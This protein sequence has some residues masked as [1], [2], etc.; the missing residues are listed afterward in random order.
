[1]TRH[2]TVRYC[3]SCPGVWRS[4]VAWPGMPGSPI[5]S[6][7]SCGRLHCHLVLS[8]HGRSMTTYCLLQCLHW[9]HSI[10]IC[11][12]LRLERATPL[13]RCAGDQAGEVWHDAPMGSEHY[14]PQIS[15][16]YEPQVVQD[17]ERESS[18][19]VTRASPEQ[20]SMRSNGKGRTE[21]PHARCTANSH[22]GP[23]V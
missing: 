9:H 14:D 10:N 12:C 2:V 18:P 7:M 19:S 22:L 23:V 1:M 8:C 13:P 21:V 16:Q 6:V 4:D 15:L 5:P 20:S 11:S 3:W 17:S